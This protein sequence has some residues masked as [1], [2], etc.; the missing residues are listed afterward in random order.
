MLNFRSSNQCRTR[1]DIDPGAYK[2]GNSR[3]GPVNR[4]AG[5][6]LIGAGDDEY[7]RV[8]GDQVRRVLTGEVV[9]ALVMFP[10]VVG[11]EIFCLFQR[12]GDVALG[13]TQRIRHSEATRFPSE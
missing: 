8:D 9:G 3:T 10:V 1:R 5:D 4:R 7:R 12:V 2:P 6:L 13:H 11:I